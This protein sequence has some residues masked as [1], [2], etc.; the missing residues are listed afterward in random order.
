MEIPKKIVPLAHRKIHPQD[1]AKLG[2]GD[3]Y[4]DHMFNYDYYDGQW[5]NPRIVPFAPLQLS[6]A[7]M[8]LH[9][10]QTIFEGLKCYRQPDGRL[11]L[12]RPHE[13]FKRFN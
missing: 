11:G 12:F 10:S 13:N 3:I 7:A 1:E 9:Y 8:V 6:P 2:F 5:R 4:T